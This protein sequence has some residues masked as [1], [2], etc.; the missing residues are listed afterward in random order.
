MTSYAYLGQHLPK[1]PLPQMLPFG[2]LYRLAG[3]CLCVHMLISYLIKAIV[4]CHGV[5]QTFFPRTVDSDNKEGWKHWY[6]VTIGMF[7]KH[8]S[9]GA[10]TVTTKRGGDT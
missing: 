2:P 5:H 7:I 6:I 1:L 8:S 4:T 9:P 3:L 10:W